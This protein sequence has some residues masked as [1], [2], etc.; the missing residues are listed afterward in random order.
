MLLQPGEQEDLNV[1]EDVCC[2]IS[3]LPL[4]DHEA[5]ILHA[6]GGVH[7][8]TARISPG[9][10]RNTRRYALVALTNLAL[11]PIP[12]SAMLHV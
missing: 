7:A 6:A 5:T 4:Q 8:L 11:F 9:I 12:R 1:E 10:N 2:V 3:R